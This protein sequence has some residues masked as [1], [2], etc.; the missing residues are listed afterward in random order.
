MR[1]IDIDIVIGGGGVAGAVTAIALQQLGYEVL[2]VEPGLNHD[3]RLAGELLHPPGVAGLA[4]LG[5]LNR[6]RCEPAMA[7]NGFCIS[8][9][10]EA[11]RI[12]LPYEACPSH[13][14]PGLSLD[15]GLIRQRLMQA[16]RMLPRVT[17]ID[18]ARVV[19]VDQ[20]ERDVTV[21]VAEGKVVTQ[22]RSRL[23]VAA[24]GASS[25]IRRLAG[26]GVQKRRISTLFGYRVPEAHLPQ[27]DYGF[28][29]LGGRTPVLAYP[30]DGNGV[31][32]MFDIPYDANRRPDLADCLELTAM[33]PS[34]L[35]C[36]VHNCITTQGG[37]SAVIQEVIADRLASGRVVLIGDAAVTCHPLTATG[38]TMCITDALLL[39]DAIA[40]R[41]GDL[42]QALHLHQRH[43]RWRQVTRISLA[44]ALRDVFC[45]EN[46]GM[47]PVQRGI[48]HYWR[49]SPGGRRASMALLSTADGR[50]TALIHQFARVVLHGLLA[51]MRDPAETARGGPRS[52]YG[53]AR[54][55]SSV[56]VRQLWQVLGKCRTIWTWSTSGT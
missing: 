21:Q 4:E 9:G 46:S 20:S 14:A 42:G 2:V 17:V 28:V 29:F 1:T 40:E 8:S 19:G 22:Y 23:L 45:G 24:D 32:I 52:A 34:D 25:P 37:P 16:A 51:E 44:E 47:R 39:R 13:C 33:L 27:R 7:I 3:R 49:H 36:A 30:V 43:R 41:P 31:R 35:R 10:P 11:E 50:L 55:L 15:H 6:L 38:M 5:V 26:I 48:I 12:R 53:L 54:D 56:L 18:D